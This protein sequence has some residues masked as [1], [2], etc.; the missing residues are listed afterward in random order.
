MTQ[1]VCFNCGAIKWGAFSNCENCGS[2]P[3][4]DDELMVSLALTDHYFDLAKLHQ[5]GRD[6]A[7]GKAPQLDP[8]TKEGLRPAIEQA[9]I[10]LGINH[11]VRPRKGLGVEPPNA[12]IIANRGLVVARKNFRLYLILGAPVWLCA[13]ALVAIEQPGSVHYGPLLVFCLILPLLPTVVWLIVRDHAVSSWR[14]L[15]VNI[16]KGLTRAYLTIAVPWIAWF[17]Y[18]IA[19]YADRASY[20]TNARQH[21]AFSIVL[22]LL[23]PLG[24]PVLLKLLIWIVQGFLS[25]KVNGGK[26]ANPTDERPSIQSDIDHLRLR[27]AED[28]ACRPDFVVNK[29]LRTGWLFGKHHSGWPRL[30]ETKLSA[31]Q[32]AKLPPSYYEKGGID[33]SLLGSTVGY[34]SGDAMIDRLI[35]LQDD[36][37]ASGS[38]EN[39]VDNLVDDEITR[40]LKREHQRGG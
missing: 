14:A 8:A 40:R 26:A 39:L 33:P 15:P 4:S 24:A 1:A 34:A 27:V 23:V 12:E 11:G 3:K 10:M 7:D 17:G 9:K 35:K 31:E 29:Y 32:K 37:R 6:V 18:Q 25:P 20:S 5:M 2:R 30:D 13:L 22:F 21:L 19:L 36:V 28:L 38:L 16:R